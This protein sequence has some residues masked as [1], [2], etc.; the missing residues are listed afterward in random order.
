MIP[1]FVQ[2][3]SSTGSIFSENAIADFMQILYF[4]IILSNL[5]HV[6]LCHMTKSV[7]QSWNKNHGRQLSKTDPLLKECVIFPRHLEKTCVISF[8]PF[9]PRVL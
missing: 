5:S 9:V 1:S 2:M 7:N 6:A 8:N 3:S 4:F